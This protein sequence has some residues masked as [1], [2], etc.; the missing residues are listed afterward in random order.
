MGLDSRGQGY[1]GAPAISGKFS[2]VQAR[3]TEKHASALYVHCALHLL[4]LVF[5]DACEIQE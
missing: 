3:I 5:P 1:D 2:S 4:N